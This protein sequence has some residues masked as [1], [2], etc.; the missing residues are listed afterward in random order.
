MSL[1]PEQARALL[2]T[3]INEV[4]EKLTNKHINPIASN[5]PAEDYEAGTSAMQVASEAIDVVISI[6]K[7][8]E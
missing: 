6:F 4:K 1:T 3:L 5:R 2:T 7:T 8:E